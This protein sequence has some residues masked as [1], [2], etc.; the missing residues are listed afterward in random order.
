MTIWLDSHF[1]PELAAWLGSR[2]KVVAKSIREIGLTQAEDDALFA[3][4]RRFSGIVVLTKDYDFVELVQR[5]GS[6]PQVIWLRC[7]N[8]RT[9]RLQALLS[10]TFETALDRIREG[11]PLVEITVTRTDAH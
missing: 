5:L 9:V 10:G 6:P 11:A 4:A 8:M 1:D 3:A 7:P 2:F